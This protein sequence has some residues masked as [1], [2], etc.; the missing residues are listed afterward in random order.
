MFAIIVYIYHFWDKKKVIH[1]QGGEDG[2]ISIDEFP[3]V[4]L[5][6]SQIIITDGKRV[7]TCTWIDYNSDGK[8]IMS[9]YDRS[10]ITHW[11]PMPEPKK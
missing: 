7:K 5:I 6:D 4:F 2:W 8:P 11:M 10:L 3:G 9:T 1:I